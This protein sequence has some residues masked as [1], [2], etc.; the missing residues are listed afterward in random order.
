VAVNKRVF[1]SCLGVSVGGG[2]RLQ[3]ATSVGISASR[4]IS[5]SYTFQ[6]ANPVVT[7]AALPEI[8]VTVASYLSS[9]TALHTEEGVNDWTNIA[10]YAGPENCHILASNQKNIFDYMLLNSVK[11]N[12]PSEG[13]F[14][15]ERTYKGLNKKPCTISETCNPN[16]P[17]QSG[18]VSTRRH[19]VSGKPSIVQNNPI[20]NISIDISINRNFINEFGTRKPYASY[21]NFP[22][23]TSCT[24]ECIVQNFDD[25]EFDLNQTAC[26]N[27][28]LTPENISIAICNESAGNSNFTISNAFLTNFSYTGAE[29][30]GNSSLS[31]S[32]TY[33]GYMASSSINP[34][35]IVPD[36]FNDPCQPT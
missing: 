4:S 11:Y 8:E 15:V 26:K 16:Q 35:I 30:T 24:F 22:I 25:L 10:I 23:E 19:Y 5:N 17:N 33:T 27:I 32:A 31:F 1:Y 14:T 12:L 6:N 34:V 36:T 9:F 18:T 2:D 3:G 13:F 29:A 21:I 20:T 7:Y 28:D